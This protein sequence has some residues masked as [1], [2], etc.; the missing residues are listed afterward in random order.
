MQDLKYLTFMG[1]GPKKI[2]H[3]EHWSNPDAETWLTGINYYD[4]P[5]RCREK[6]KELY[7]FYIVNQ[8]PFSPVSPL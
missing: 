3:W 2:P 5:R 8:N 1:L 4:E 6:L 7:E